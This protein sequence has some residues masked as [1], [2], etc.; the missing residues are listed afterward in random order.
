MESVESNQK[1]EASNA[2]LPEV[3]TMLC[4]MVLYFMALALIPVVND[5]V[6]H[7]LKSGSV[8]LRVIPPYM[9]VLVVALAMT[10]AMRK[11]NASLFYSLWGALFFSVI[12][13]YFLGPFGTHIEKLVWTFEFI[14]PVPFIVVLIIYIWFKKCFVQEFIPSLLS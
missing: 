13:L 3:L 10:N 12:V 8:L 2:E 14:L 9:V 6:Y 11:E 1:I 5:L 7:N 4:G